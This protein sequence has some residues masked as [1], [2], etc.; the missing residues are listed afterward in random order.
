MQS[1][2]QLP[3]T[4]RALVLPKKGEP[5]RVE[6]VP[7]PVATPGSIVVRVLA[8]PIV[9]YIR[10]VYS[11]ARPSYLPTPLV[12]GTSAI[13]RVASI[14]PDASSLKPGDL[15]YLD[16]FIGGRDDPNNR[17]LWGVHG[18]FSEGSRKLMEGE[19]R[20]ASWAEYAKVPLENCVKLDEEKLLVQMKYT[21]EQLSFIAS[22]L[23][24]YGGL[25]D[26]DVRPGET[27]II[28][29]ATGGFGGAAVPVAMAMGAGK[30]IAMGRNMEKL[31]SLKKLSDRIKIVPISGDVEKDATELKKFGEAD[32]FFDISPTAA[33]TAPHLKSG[34]M[35]LRSGGRVSLMGGMQGDVPLPH[36]IIMQKNIA[37]KG[38]WMYNREDIPA[39]IK[40]VET[41][42]LKVDEKSGIRIVGTFKLEDWDEAFTVAEEKTKEMGAMAIFK[43]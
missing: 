30:V 24:P 17:I 35:A 36:A 2:S 15:V 16:V 39:L 43:P 4:H 33:G 31:N 13:G 34:I 23:I 14:G 25:R 3:K 38:K 1:P 37:L 9:S 26:V 42:L 11:G 10:E 22:A 5:L 41:G 18:G 32:V 28:A 8:A 27:V 29:P 19:W 20:D 6:Q 7:T 40:L 21:V 12:T